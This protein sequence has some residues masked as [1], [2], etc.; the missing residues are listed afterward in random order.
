MVRLCAQ[1]LHADGEKITCAHGRGSMMRVV[2]CL[3]FCY[4]LLY[5]ALTA[6]LLLFH[7][8]VS[9]EEHVP[10]LNRSTDTS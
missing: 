10:L 6:V 4:S 9:R 7:A 8:G 3:L 2:G 1:C 5:I